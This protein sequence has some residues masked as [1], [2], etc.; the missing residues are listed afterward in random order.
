MPY[1]TG[2]FGS[3]S[4][5]VGGSALDRAAI[6]IIAKGKMIAA[7]L[8]EASAGDIAF[9]DG[10]FAVAGT[11]RQLTCA[12]WRASRNVRTISDRTLEPGLQDNRRLRPADLR[13]EQRRTRLRQSRSIATRRNR[14]VGYWGVDD[15]GTVINP[16]IVDGQVQGGVAQGLARPPCEHLPLRSDDG[17]L[18][19]GS[20]MD[21]ALPRAADMP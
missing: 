4:I 17:Q 2:T 10:V 19:S 21:Y 1:G 6:K 20:F 9:A 15:V 11:D 5:A 3:R 18:L 14:I 13:L 7:H 16:M 8:L 12:R